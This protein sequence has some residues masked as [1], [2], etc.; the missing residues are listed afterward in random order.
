MAR[1]SQCFITIS[2]SSRNYDFNKHKI[3]WMAL[4]KIYLFI[5]LRQVLVAALGIFDLHSG[6]QDLQS[7]HVNSES[8]CAGF[9]SLT[10][11]W[12]Q[13]PCTGSTGSY[14][15]LLWSYWTTREVLGWLTAAT[16]IPQ[17]IYLPFLILWFV[18]WKM[19]HELKAG[20]TL[21][22]TL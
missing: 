1:S 8:Q 20:I 6:T 14:C 7:Q 21:T 12:A 11:G 2:L 19:E 10:R 9:S 22:K 3:N 4:L 15:V 5:W 18:F 13:A 17:G 16:I